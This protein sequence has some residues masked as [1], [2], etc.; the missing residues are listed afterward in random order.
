MS[1]MGAIA[2][3]GVL[4]VGLTGF[5]QT[6]PPRQGPTTKV[7]AIGHVVSPVD[8]KMMPTEVKDT[9]KLYL[10]GKLEQWFSRRDVAGVVFVLNATS[11][12]EAREMLAKLPLV[13][14]KKMEFE[15]IPL[16]PLAPLQFLMEEPKGDGQH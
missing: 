12:D 2:M 11:V 10:G 4:G 14:S 6:I 5:G 16:G 8:Q 3:C 1:L 7:L 15:L 13:V 9:V